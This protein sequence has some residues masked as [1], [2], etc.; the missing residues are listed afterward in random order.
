MPAG[1]FAGVFFFLGLENGGCGSTGRNLA[2]QRGLAR[3]GRRVW[4]LETEDVDVDVDGD[5]DGDGDAGG[6]VDCSG[7][8]GCC[9]SL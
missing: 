5:G 3:A 1:F 2:D 4:S 9:C 6:D 7:D 8:S